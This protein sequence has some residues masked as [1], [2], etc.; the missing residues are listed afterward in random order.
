M[1]ILIIPSERLVPE[2]HPLEG[3]F[4][5]HQAVILAEAGHTVGAL[6]IDLSFSVPMIAKGLFFKLT[7]RK[8]ANKTDNLSMGA[9]LKLGVEKVFSAAKFIHRETL[10]GVSVYRVEALYRRKPVANKNHVSWVRAGA[11]CFD[12]Y[13]KEKGRPDVVHAHE[14]IYAG[15]LA[16]TI[17]EQYNIPYVITEHSTFYATGNPGEDVLQRVKKAYTAA[18]GLFAVSKSFASF[19]NE[20]FGLNRFR[21][22]PNVLDVQLETA[23]FEG[24]A[25]P[26]PNV[27]FLNIALFKP[28]KD[29]LT[30]LKAFK[31]VAGRVEN[32]ELCIG[33]SGAMEAELRSF[34]G[35]AGLQKKVHFLGVLSREQVIAELNRCDCFVLSSKYETFG[36]VI[37]EAL[38]FG[39]PVIST[40]VGVAPDIINRETGFVVNTG[41]EKALAEAMLELINN[42][43][44]YK[45][46]G[47]RRFAVAEFGKEAFVKRMNKIYSEVA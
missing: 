6:S 17:R 10:N 22:L 3:I 40:A 32:A 27:R 37:I 18:T 30:L 43:A 8:A 9:L 31:E 46:E 23:S 36:V 42:K 35:Q 44:A 13:V 4:P 1:H 15:M 19:L 28:V 45:A 11:L 20:K 38:L 7:G 29:Q 5:Y 16:Q 41:D 21:Y 33:G 47:I 26:Y 14:A 25:G 2:G 39:K 12:V 34:V 24:Q